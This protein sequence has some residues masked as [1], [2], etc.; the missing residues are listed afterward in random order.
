MTSSAQLE[1]EA[2]QARARLSQTLGE[3]RERITPGQIVDEAVDFARGSGGGMFVRNLG[4]QVKDN[5]LPVTLIGAGMA[6]LMLS[7]GL[8][9][10][11]SGGDKVAAIHRARQAAIDAAAQ[12]SQSS[13][14]AMAAL[15][16]AATDTSGRASAAASRAASPSAAASS[17]S[18]RTADV[19]KNFL[20]FCKSEPLVLAGLGMAL[21]AI[22]GTLI[23]PT[24]SEDRL[25]GAKS[26]KLKDQARNA[27][28]E[29]TQ[30][31]KSAAQ[32]P[33][34]DAEAQ[35]QFPDTGIQSRV[36]A[37]T[38]LV[39]DAEHNAEPGTANEAAG[40]DR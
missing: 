4:Q 23:P 32:G 19:G 40:Q 29:M 35:F 25:M 28:K 17:F 2:E 7:N 1:R 13:T 34:D 16:E 24:E 12:M 31:A 9:S 36:P 10:T 22:I 37:E 14:D 6:W 8:R 21:G 26:D 18:A 38:S 11:G 33:F 15:T 3:L 30:K 20:Q 27:A 39:P 5:P